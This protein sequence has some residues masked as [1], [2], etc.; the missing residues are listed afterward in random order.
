MT[1]NNERTEVT[2]VRLV[3]SC[4]DYTQRSRERSRTYV[5]IPLQ[6]EFQITEINVN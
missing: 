6:I 5:F 3:T 2:E 4:K 1:E